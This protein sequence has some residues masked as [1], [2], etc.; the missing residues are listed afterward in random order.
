MDD[1]DPIWEAGKA[2]Y[3]KFARISDP[4]VLDRRWARLMPAVR[5]S[6]IAEAKVAIST[7]LYITE[8]RTDV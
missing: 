5:D 3:G 7:F 8:G 1:P 4:D 6:F 2:L